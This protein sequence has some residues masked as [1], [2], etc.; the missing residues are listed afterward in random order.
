MTADEQM[1]LSYYRAGLEQ[2][3]PE[4]VPARVKLVAKVR[5]DFPF[6]GTIVSAG[7][8]DCECNQWGAVSVH[9]ND[10]SLLGIKPN[11]FEPI[12]WCNNPYK[13]TGGQA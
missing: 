5:G 8:H 9:A 7:E 3:M 6:N 13:T 12:A 4:Y 1:A 11:E 10:G 2:R